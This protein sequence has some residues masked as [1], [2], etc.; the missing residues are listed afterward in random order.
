MH[1]LHR[2]KQTNTH[3]HTHTHTH[4]PQSWHVFI[5]WRRKLMWIEGEKK[6]NSAYKSICLKIK[7]L[8]FPTGPTQTDLYCNRRWLEASKFGFRKK[9][10][11]T[12]YGAKTKALISCA[13]TA[14]LICAF[15]LALFRWFTWYSP[16]TGS[17]SNR[18]KSL[19]LSP[20]VS[21]LT[22]PVIPEKCNTSRDVRKPV[23]WV[24][25]QVRHKPSCTSTEDD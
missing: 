16:D 4:S 3:R 10:Y 19:T 12:I 15:G 24:S 20:L 17:I 7:N 22:T 11:H 18:E 1:S 13:V 9:R 14:Q 2:P 8:G 21:M 6:S 23:F 25:D 5:N